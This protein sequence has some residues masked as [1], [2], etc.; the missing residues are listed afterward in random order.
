M[1]HTAA[2]ARHDRV[3]DVQASIQ[4][5]ASQQPAVEELRSELAVALE[6]LRVADEELRA[7]QEHLQG[8]L[9]AQAH[10]RAAHQ[11]LVS[12][13]PTPALVTDAHG[14]V[15]VANAAAAALLGT[16]L[17]R[18]ERRAIFSFVEA[19]ARP[20]LRSRL[21]RAV[22]EGA[23]GFE[24]RVE[25]LRAHGR[26]VMV[27]LAVTI[28]RSESAPPIQEAQVTWLLLGADDPASTG[29]AE[30]GDTALALALVELSG[31][32]LQHRD[33]AEV[34]RTM[35]RLSQQAFSAPVRLSLTLGDPLTPDEVATDSPDAQLADGA[36][37][38][39]GER[40]CVDAW[41]THS[42]VTSDDMAA[43]ARWPRLHRHVAELEFRAA[44]ALPL[45]VGGTPVGVLALYSAEPAP[46]TGA[47][48]GA[49]E[50]VASTVSTV[51]QEVALRDELEAVAEQLRTALTS[52][53]TIDQAKG[54]VMARHG[55]DA[56]EA[57]RLLAKI[58][59]NSNVKLREIAERLV[60]EAARRR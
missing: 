54:I 49:A 57:F 36:Q 15:R 8:L 40:P 28:D 26:S 14:S 39:A 7:Q 33:R 30:G 55:C 18:L 23:T 58:S 10:G 29:T 6:Q 44:L 56:D 3:A 13:L 50:L 5:L 9:T 32:P 43:D 4:Q 59:S 2:A 34:L 27:D 12:R 21:S 60:A 17:H 11:Q 47:V 46:A 19:S 52:R 24:S 31:A 22:A 53:A 45:L 42:R 35:A 1:D 37:L 16:R 48:P 25:L 51:L 38:I 41:H 20:G